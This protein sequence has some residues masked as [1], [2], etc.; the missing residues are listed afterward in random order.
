LA[1]TLAVLL[2][3]FSGVGSR[4]TA[5]DDERTAIALARSKLESIGVESPLADGVTEGKFEIG[6]GWKLEVMP[7][8]TV[9]SPRDP[10]GPRHIALTVHWPKA[11][12][13]H[14]VTINGLRVGGRQ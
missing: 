8:G 5:L 6:F 14:A 11:S 3:V 12:G 7:Y 9:E 1:I 4:N 2:P 13:P 10:T